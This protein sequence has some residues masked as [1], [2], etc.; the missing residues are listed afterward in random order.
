MIVLS[1][2]SDISFKLL[3]TEDA[4]VDGNYPASTA[5]QYVG[6]CSLFGFLVCAGALDSALTLQVKQDTSATETASIKVV[7]SATTIIGATGD[8]KWYLI[9]VNPSELDINNDFAYV[10]LAISG[11]TGN[12]YAAVLFFKIPASKP[13]SA[14]STRGAL[15]SL[16]G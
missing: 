9:Q 10:T 16:L 8:D 4:I 14:D 11:A 1:D 5:Y 6:D 15:V 3:N 13:A 2:M 7:T 12:D